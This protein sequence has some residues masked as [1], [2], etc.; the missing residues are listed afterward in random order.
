MSI[1]YNEI[2]QKIHGELKMQEKE[3]HTKPLADAQIQITN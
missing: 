2:N 1:I 3:Y